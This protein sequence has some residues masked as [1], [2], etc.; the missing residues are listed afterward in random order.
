LSG[1][2]RS[3]MAAMQRQGSGDDECLAPWLLSAADMAVLAGLT[4]AGRL[5]CA[6]QLAGAIMA[7][8]RMMKPI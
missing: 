7:A 2:Q 6:A 3:E 8:F 5:G 4:G 1:E